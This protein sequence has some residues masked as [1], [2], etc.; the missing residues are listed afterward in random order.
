MSNKYESENWWFWHRRGRWNEYYKQWLWCSKRYWRCGLVRT[1]FPVL[2]CPICKLKISCLS[3]L[4][5][6]RFCSE[7]LNVFIYAAAC[8]KFCIFQILK[9][10]I[11]PSFKRTVHPSNSKNKCLLLDSCHLTFCS[12]V[13][14]FVCNL[15]VW[16]SL[17][18][19]QALSRKHLISKLMGCTVCLKEV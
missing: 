6:K 7:H 19:R 9:G 12:I 1:D 8:W 2:S 16:K 15:P 3:P 4:I 10:D 5:F 13:P 18:K 17:L 14:T 11:Y